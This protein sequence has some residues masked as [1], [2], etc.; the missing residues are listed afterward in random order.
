MNFLLQKLESHIEEEALIEG[1]QLLE[2]GAADNLFELEKHLW[3]ATVEG[4]EV[5]LKVSPSKVLAGT[6]EC[7]RFAAEG[8]CEH[9]AAVMMALRRQQQAR[10]QKQEK[11]KKESLTPRKL[12]TGI[13]L[14]HV[15]LEELAEFVRDYAKANRNFA[16]ALKARFASTVSE[17]GGKEKYMQ[18][19]DS[20]IKAVRKPDR[21]ISMRGSQRLIKVLA[22]LHL[23]AGQAIMERDFLEAS[24][25]C[26]SIIEKVTPVLK[27]T[28]G[29]KQELNRD[30][31]RAFD[32][33][34]R[35]LEKGPAPT[36]LRSLWEYCLQ[37]YNKLVYR[38]SGIDLQFFKLMVQLAHEPAQQ[39]ALLEKLQ[40]YTEK[41]REEDRPIAPLMLIELSALERAG[42][43]EEARRLMESNLMQPDVLLYA[44]QQAI[45]KG[46]IPRVK[47]LAI[48][49]LRFE[50]PPEVKAR[51]EEMMLQLAEQDDEPEE[52]N[53]YALLRFLDTQNFAYLEKAR[54]SAGS[55]WA[56]QVEDTLAH[57][58]GLPY[59]PSRR[60][61]IARILAEEGL[62]ERLMDYAEQV[63]SLDLLQE[64]APYLIDNHR[65]RLLEL[66]RKL[67]TDFLR[68]HLGRKTSQR[69][70]EALQR[71]HEIGAGDMAVLLVEEFRSQYPE[72]HSLMEELA[73][74]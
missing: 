7:E 41:Y 11:A 45:T 1:E 14:D 4:C 65:E 10:K 51:L 39:K 49:G 29:K 40:H 37:E 63:Q 52:V 59:A 60:N 43:P 72:R 33:L 67:L 57:F 46:Q 74:F 17:I 19:L 15:N 24:F 47:A 13:V 54:R 12:T 44:I 5:E 50:L 32:N 68:N 56:Q 21:S 9:L 8:M 53:R 30:I 22:E 58:Q 35:L 38:S 66:Y 6:C 27:K 61:T 36:L 42:Q 23:Q 2:A 16:I 28:Q 18:L 26:Q 20:S 71:L 62:H 48:T 55:D 31:S 34:H 3:L 64:F 73:L 69:I 25:I 70:R